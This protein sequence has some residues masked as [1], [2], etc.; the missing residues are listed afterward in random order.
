MVRFGIVGAGGIA[1]KF[2]KDIAYV[3]NATITAVSGR[4]KESAE[5]Y[6]AYFKVEHAFSSYE[7]MAKS[8]VI[9]AVYIATPHNFHYEH[10]LLFIRNKKHVLVEKPIT[11]NL[12]Q[13]EELLLEAKKHGVL[14]MEAMWTHF[15]PA[16]RYVKELADSK[17]YGNLV[18]AK[19]N[20]GFPLITFYPDEKRLL[21]PDLAGGSLLDLGVY[22]LSFYNL[23][24][25]VPIKTIDATATFTH[26]GVDDTCHVEIVD[27]SNARIHIKSSIS[28]MLLDHALLTFANGII[29]LKNFHGCRR[30]VINGKRKTIPYEGEGFVHEIRAFANDV[31]NNL[32]EDPILTHQASRESMKLMDDIRQIIGL[33]YPFEQ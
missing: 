18:E 12:N 30:L 26:T 32:L 3:K 23:I 20:F 8:D 25:Q 6:K 13:Y 17:A 5:K 21:N 31:E 27:D 7:E 16:I 1:K 11:V 2:G 14:I 33:K 10:T 24:K 28:K 22:P 15:L 4:S 9:D 29:E 19:I